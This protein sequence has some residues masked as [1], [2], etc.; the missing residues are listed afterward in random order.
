MRAIGFAPVSGIVARLVGSVTGRRGRWAV[1]AV[2]IALGTAGFL[3]HAHLNEVTAAG[4]SSYLPKHAQSTRVVSQLQR[5]YKNGNDVPVL[6]VFVREDGGRLTASEL[7]AIGRAGDGLEGLGLAGPTPVFAPY[8]GD[9]DRLLGKIATIARGV[10][11][12]SRD[13]RAAL[14]AL[15]LNAGEH[16]AI[17]DGVAKLRRYLRRHR[18]PGLR[19]YVTG[20]GAVA[21]DLERVADDAGRTL[22]LAALGLVLV[23]LLLV[24]RAP[25]LALL[26][27]LT[28]GAAYLV[29]TGVVYLL[30]EAGLIEVNVEGT[31]LLLVLIFGAGLVLAGTFATLTLL[32]L[33]GLVQIGAAVAAGVLLDTF[34]VRALLI[35]AIT[36]LLDERAWWPGESGDQSS[37]AASEGSPVSPSSSHSAG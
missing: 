34:V 36:Y 8:S 37:A 27:L 22:L 2:W 11:P 32:P 4:Q 16:G 15:A 10:G 7:N 35:P 28:V 30:I 25:A 33:E 17:G 21:A 26:P 12:I 5:S 14:L 9:S 24:Y 6:V 23:L 18:A 1:L 19:S 20:P 13:H 29:A 31:L 3:A